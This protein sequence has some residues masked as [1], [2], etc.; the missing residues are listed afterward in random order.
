MADTSEERLSIGL[1][2]HPSAAAYPVFKKTALLAKKNLVRLL[3]Q[4]RRVRRKPAILEA[5][6]SYD[7]ATAPPPSVFLLSKLPHKAARFMIAAR[8]FQC[9]SPVEE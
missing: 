7:L 9:L 5:G 1:L 4:V 6:Q 2:K 3:S 8:H